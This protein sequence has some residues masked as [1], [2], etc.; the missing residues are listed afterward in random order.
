MT[1]DFSQP[2]EYIRDCVFVRVE[3]APVI[4]DYADMYLKA[5]NMCE[6]SVSISWSESVCLMVAFIIK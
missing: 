5:L 4:A 3:K 6:E 2:L 1:N